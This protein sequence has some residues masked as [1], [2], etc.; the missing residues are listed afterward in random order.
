MAQPRIA[1]LLKK[2]P[3]LSETFVLNEILE[4]ERRGTQVHVFSRRTPDDEPRHAELAR[5]KAEI[6]QVPRKH[7]LN[8][9]EE[10]FA[11]P[12]GAATTLA[13]IREILAD[14][15]V[16]QHPRLTELLGE[17]LFLLRRSRELEIEH[18]HVH[19]ATDSA[20]TAMLLSRLGGPGYS[21]TMHAKDI[22][23]TAIRPELLQRIVGDSRFTV[24]VCD[25]NV[26]YLNDMLNEA[27]RTK[28]RRLYNG[29]ELES[30]EVPP[31]QQR[32]ANRVLAVG[33]LVEKKGFDVL[34]DALALLRD[35]EIPFEATIL[36][37]GDSRSA[38]LAQLEELDLTDKVE[39]PG[40]LP[41]EE[42][43]EHMGSATVFCLPCVIGEDGNRDALPTVLLEALASGLPAISTP[44]TGIP[45]ILDNGGAGVIV[46]ERD[47][48][49]TADALA[50]LLGDPIERQSL[51][52]AGL[53]RVHRL[54]DLAKS[55]DS[56]NRWFGEAIR[57][58][59]CA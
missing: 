19:F 11:S 29:I 4:Q 34:L 14:N 44:V 20:I 1:Y 55:G 50:Q 35:R 12:D 22:Y 38:L 45:E 37:D 23:R 25:A 49:A 3:R 48:E 30:F 56:L 58:E 24:T 13:A 41:L 8:P 52:L 16:W 47:A 36:G 32:S 26:C 5:L 46:P 33:R 21:V 6:E 17:A 57:A 18:V 53:E 43:R 54:F 51:A 27:A 59:V 28:L 10:L 15:E 2:F 9:W 42:I 7:A 31:S 40:A 39:L